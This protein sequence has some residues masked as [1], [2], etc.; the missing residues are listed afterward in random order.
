MPQYSETDTTAAA[1]AAAP[2]QSQNRSIDIMKSYALAV[3]EISC[4][5]IKTNWRMRDGS[6]WQ[7]K[8]NKK[9]HSKT[10]KK[11]CIHLHGRYGCAVRCY[12]FGWCCK[13]WN[14][15]TEGKNGVYQ[16]CWRFGLFL[17]SHFAVGCFAI[18]HKEILFLT[19][20]ENCL[21]NQ[22]VTPENLCISYWKTSAIYYKHVHLR[23]YAHRK[24][25]L[26]FCVLFFYF[27]VALF[28]AT[29]N[30][31]D[32]CVVKAHWFH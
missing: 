16:V 4:T 19:G 18:L 22:I 25:P 32:D 14:K 6:N 5:K 3:R 17:R 24:F 9:K 1:A 26:F 12:G 29:I 23:Q 7:P 30:G 20:L 2:Q 21:P 10:K 31:H 15:S 13:K 11:K 8:T 27:S 28:V